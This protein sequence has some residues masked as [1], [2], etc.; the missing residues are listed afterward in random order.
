MAMKASV[1]GSALLLL[2]AGCATTQLASYVPVEGQVTTYNQ[3]IGTIT[4]SDDNVKLMMY[5]TFRYQS[6][7]DIPT[8]TLMVENKTNHPFDFNP[9]KVTALLDGEECHIYTLEERVAEIRTDARNR[10]IALAIIGGIAA[11]AA[12]YNASHTQTTY[13]SWGRVGN[14][15]FYSGGVINTY[16]PLAGMF[17]GA[18]VGG[19]AAVGIHQIDVA[20]GHEEQAA[21][22]IFQRTTI[23]PG[24]TVIGQVMIRRQR[25]S[26]PATYSAG[27]PSTGTSRVKSFKSVSINVPAETLQ[28]SFVFDNNVV[29]AH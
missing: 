19:I 16:D 21:Q 29:T 17:A 7:D 5:P 11:G 24:V 20:A 12:A 18:A 28:G 13:S 10:Q 27:H 1:V 14:S 22:A 2:L 25:V 4:S 15:N 9:G 26:G 8:F 6:P 23:A 3:G